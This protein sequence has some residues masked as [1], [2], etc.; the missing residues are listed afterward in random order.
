MKIKRILC[1]LLVVFTL[2]AAFPMAAFAQTTSTAITASDAKA[3]LSK[4][5]AT[6]I[7]G[8]KL[9]LRVKNKVGKVRWSSS[10]KS[11]ATVNSKGVVTAKKLGTAT[12]TARLAN[13]KKLKCKVTVVAPTPTA[14]VDPSPTI[15]ALP[16]EP[17]AY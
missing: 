17:A 5:T 3:K 13:G 2:V 14:P 9:K 6:V 10:K 12:I 15:P 8:K 1:A 16:T 11:V 4:K 7:I